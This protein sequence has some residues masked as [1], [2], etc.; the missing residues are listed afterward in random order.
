M[1]DE[2]NFG[3]GAGPSGGAGLGAGLGTGGTTAGT[4]AGAANTPRFGEG[5]EARVNEAM[6]RA[7]DP[8]ESAADRLE[9]LADR[10]GTHG[11][12]REL[13]TVAHTAADGLEA[14]ASYLRGNDLRGLLDDIERMVDERP[15]QSLLVAI[16][17]GWLVGKILR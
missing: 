4:G 13:G 8:L 9:D 10:K 12:H 2:R 5:G 14:A 17:A 15:V 1:Q 11:A 6:H 16:G 3:G 7:A